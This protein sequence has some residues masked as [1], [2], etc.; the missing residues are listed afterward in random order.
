MMLAL[1]PSAHPIDRARATRWLA[2]VAAVLLAHGWLF[3]TAPR[4]LQR[5]RPASAAV[6]L[7]RVAAPL[8]A[9][10]TPAL[11]T[12]PPARP[13]TE[14][15]AAPV[16]PRTAPA[17]AA[18]AATRTGPIELA[19]APAAAATAPAAPAAPNADAPPIYPTR[20]PDPARLRYRVRTLQAEGEASLVWQHDGERYTMALDARSA[21]AERP[22]LEQ[23]SKGSFDGAGL[24]PD[25]FTDRRRGRS[26]QAANF[27]RETGRIRFSGPRAELPAWPGTQDRLAWIAQLAAIAA[28]AAPALPN[29][30][31]IQ[32][33]GSRGGAG[34]WTFARLADETVDT[35]LGALQALHLQRLPD[36]PEDLGVEVWLDPARGFWPARLVLTTPRRGRVLELVL[37]EEPGP[38]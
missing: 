3:S 4:P 17:P 18:L 21:V 38:P 25:R 19:Q 20:L 15:A 1:P 36:R 13:S 30:I 37:A 34:R 9:A 11:V 31:A 28:A 32:V 12:T 16:P 22:L 23:Q 35:P 29:E 2:V 26:T 8:P 5:A 6:H 7:V 14:A 10:Q 33:V 24:A 27:D